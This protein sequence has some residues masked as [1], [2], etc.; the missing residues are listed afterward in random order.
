VIDFGREIVTIGSYKDLIALINVY[1]RT[2]PH[3]KRT[4]KSKLA[5]TVLLGTTIK[6]PIIYRVILAN[7]DYLFKPE[8][9]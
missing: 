7:R 3:L 5:V 1:T 8:Y 4:I 9:T 6:V 2:S